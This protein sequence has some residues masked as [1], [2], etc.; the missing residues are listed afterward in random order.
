MDSDSK[1]IKK[2]SCGYEIKDEDKGDCHQAWPHKC[3]PQ[4]LMVEEE[5]RSDSYK[6]SS[7]CHTHTLASE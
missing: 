6:L 4:A 1:T 7:D 5:K 2:R 3:D